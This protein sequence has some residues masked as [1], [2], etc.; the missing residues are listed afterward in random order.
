MNLSF[1]SWN[2]AEQLPTHHLTTL[3]RRARLDLLLLAG[4][5]GFLNTIL[6]SLGDRWRSLTPDHD[7]STALLTCRT[8]LTANNELLTDD[9]LLTITRLDFPRRKPLLITHV[10]MPDERSGLADPI[11]R[12]ARVAERAWR[13]NRC[14]RDA[15]ATCHTNRSIVVG[16]LKMDPFHPAVLGARGLSAAMTCSEVKRSD[17]SVFGETQPILYNPMWGCYGDRTDGPSGT[18]YQIP[19]G[20]SVG[21]WHIYNQVLLRPSLMDNVREL[22]ILAS[23]GWES[24]VTSTGLPN[25]AAGIHHL[26]VLTR[27][28]V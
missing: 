12:M 15:E 21:G 13:V 3:A 25:F 27:L 2:V 8:D 4:Q 5:P 23:D 16:D 10:H 6:T 26:P 1:L 9:D 28:S 22:R 11:I 18:D 17:T 7:R 19:D 20:E 14:L 24:L